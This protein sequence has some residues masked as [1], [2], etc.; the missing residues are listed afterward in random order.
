MSDE[1]DTSAKESGPLPGTVVDYTP[2][3][4]GWICP[5]CGAAN[6]PFANQCPCS[7]AVPP[8]YPP[9]GPWK[10]DPWNP[11][12]HPYWPPSYPERL[13]ITCCAGG[14]R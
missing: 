7:P 2:K 8:C 14:R 12:T 11:P 1:K 10:T 3:P 9:V 4:T 5:R 6:A 13:T